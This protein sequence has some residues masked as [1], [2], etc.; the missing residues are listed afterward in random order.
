[1]KRVS[2]KR[3]VSSR[4]RRMQ[5]RAQSGRADGIVTEMTER[6]MC[7][8]MREYVCGMRMRSADEWVDSS[9]R[10]VDVGGKGLQLCDV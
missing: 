6:R 3:H 10:T 5:W 9:V 1:M 2:T 7:E 8:K 4:Q